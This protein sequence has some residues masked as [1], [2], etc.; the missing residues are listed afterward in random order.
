MSSQ[1]D[2]DPSNYLMCSILG[3]SSNGVSVVYLARHNPTKS[4]VAI[5]KYSMDQL[6]EE[7]S[8]LIQDEIIIMRKLSHQNV[9]KCL[10]SFVIGPD[11]LT[12][13]PLQNYRSCHDLITCHFNM[14]L[15]ELA[16]SMII[17]D[18]LQAL[19]YIH[20]MGYIHRAVRA[21]HI[22]VNDRGYSVLTGL[23]YACP[24]IVNGKIQKKVHSFPRST[25]NNLNWLSPEVLQQ[26]LLGYGEK[27][28]VYSVGITTCELAN[29]LVPYYDMASTLMLT[30]KIRADNPPQLYDCSTYYVEEDPDPGSSGD[31]AI[32]PSTSDKMREYASR[33]FSEPFHEFNDLCLL[34]EPNER[35]TPAQ[36][37]NHPFFKQIRKTNITLNE[38]L[39]PAVPI[40]EHNI[41]H[42]Q[43]DLR[44]LLAA[45][46]LSTLELTSF[47]WDF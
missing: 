35:P 7:H 16:I 18:V 44:T 3:H 11:V 47:T 4:L 1:S 22:L 37:L 46:Q 8:Q 29:G 27:S 40:T 14:G 41:N 13:T 12:I 43:S 30:E 26:N 21:G 36:L 34:R 28:D 17:K 23:S 31:N 10:S 33:K 5:K 20:G 24:T 42:Y 9:L 39:Q 2:T 6:T 32:C 45:D 25:A 38:I 19:V 15:P